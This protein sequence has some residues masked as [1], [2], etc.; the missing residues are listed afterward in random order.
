MTTIKSLKLNVS[1]IAIYDLT[2]LNDF[3]DIYIPEEFEPPM[4]QKDSSFSKKSNGVS[5]E[6]LDSKT[7]KIPELFYDATR[8]GTYFR[9]AGQPSSKGL[10]ILDKMGQH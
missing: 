1:L 7:I 3:G 4:P 2:N 5:I 6:I 10:N 8:K 9:D